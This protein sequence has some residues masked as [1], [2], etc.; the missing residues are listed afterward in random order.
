MDSES[1]AFKSDQHKTLGPM[2]TWQTVGYSST[3]IV[4]AIYFDSSVTP[5]TFERQTS[6][7]PSA[8][9]R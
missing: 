3:N 1:L 6:G 7:A 5:F 4:T 9:D 8:N 2:N